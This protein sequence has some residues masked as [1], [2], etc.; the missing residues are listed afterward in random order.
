MTCEASPPLTSPME[1]SQAT[2]VSFVPILDESSSMSEISRAIK[3]LN[4]PITQRMRALFL[5]KHKGGKEAVEALIGGLHHDSV[6]LRHEIAYVL[7]QLGNTAA[8]GVLT[9]LLD[10]ESQDDMV[11]HEAAEALAAISSKASI[12]L[13]L[14]HSNDEAAPVRETCELALIALQADKI[15]SCT[16]DLRDQAVRVSEM[17]NGTGKQQMDGLDQTED[18]SSQERKRISPYNTVDPVLL[19]SE[20]CDADTSQLSSLLRDSRAPLCRRYEAL[21]ALRNNAAE[22][23][24]QIISDFLTEDRSSA[25]LR[26]EVAFVLGQL[27]RVSSIPSLVSVSTFLHTLFWCRILLCCASVSAAK[28]NTAWPDTKQPL[29]LAPLCA[30]MSAGPRT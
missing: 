21:F 18:S 17:M 6:L 11:R 4:V 20:N 15:D 7:G 3:S 2:D 24:S 9:E 23:A 10:D 16:A 5:A 29:R 25:L 27:Q 8:E 12:D 13:L 26:H 22:E 14:K 30:A 19:T 1:S 28:T